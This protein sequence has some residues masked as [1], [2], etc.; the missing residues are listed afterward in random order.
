MHSILDKNY[1]FWIDAK[2][3]AKTEQAH[4]EDV[5]KSQGRTITR[6]LRAFALSKAVQQ[7][8]N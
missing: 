1:S 6:Q 8:D 7:A 2:T 4:S 5:K 3:A